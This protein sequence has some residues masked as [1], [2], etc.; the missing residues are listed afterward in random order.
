MQTYTSRAFTMSKD[1]QSIESM[2]KNPAL[3]Q[4]YVEKFGDKLPVKNLSFTEDSVSVEAPIVGNVT[5]SRVDTGTPGVIKYQGKGTPVPLALNI[6]LKPDGDKT[7]AQLSLDADIPAF[8]GGMIEVKAKSGLA[9]AADFLEVL[10][11]D[12]L[13]K[14]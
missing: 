6:F 8:M 5:F 14:K 13:F 10:D 1:A 7:S 12:R 4:P 9:K 11:F 3:L 2:V